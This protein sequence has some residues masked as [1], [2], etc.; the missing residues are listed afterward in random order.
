MKPTVDVLEDWFNVVQCV[1]TLERYCEGLF[2]RT[3]SLSEGNIIT[4]VSR[5]WMEGGL[6]PRPGT[7]CNSTT[8]LERAAYF[9]RYCD[10]KAVRGL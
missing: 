2:I 4:C 9:W 3:P 10:G 8:P 7:Q 6:P 1:S 5:R